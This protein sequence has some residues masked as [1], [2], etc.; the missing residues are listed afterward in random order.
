MP[1]ADAG[2]QPASEA[3]SPVRHRSALW[4]F[5]ASIVAMLA[6]SLSPPLLRMYSTEIWQALGL[7]EVQWSV[8]LAVRGLFLILF[9]MA[10]G[11]I[12]DLY[13][14]RRVL[15]LSLIGYLVASLIAATTSQQV[16]FL[17]LEN[18]LPL[19]DAFVKT[20]AVTILFLAFHDEHQRV[21]AFAAYSAFYVAAFALS[22]WLAEAIGQATE[23]RAA[24]FVISAVL[25]VAGLLLVA[26]VVPESRAS[27]RVRPRNVVALSA[28]VVG[29]CTILFA[30]LLAGNVGWTSPLVL[31]SLVAGGLTLVVLTWLQERPLRREWRVVLRFERRLTLAIVAGVVLNLSLFAVTTQ[32]FN[33]LRH[34]Q[35]YDLLGAVLRL[36]PIVAGALLLGSVAAR[37]TV[38]VGMR[39]AVAIGLLLVAAAAA[40]GALLQPDM[41]YWVLALLLVLL[42]FG[43]IVGN[44]PYLLLLSSS[45]P[46]D[47]VATAQAIGRTSSQMGSALAYALMLALIVGFGRQA[48]VGRGEAAGF[49]PAAIQQELAVL[50]EAAGDTSVVLGPEF[51]LQML[52]L[53]SPRVAYAYTVGLSRAMLVLSGVCVFGALLVY[54][55]LRAERGEQSQGSERS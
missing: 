33:F 14:R 10:A 51:G 24:A 2:V 15:L 23:V 28:W 25:T 1:E 19:F 30:I 39:N 12:G 6:T 7:T 26:R 38:R 9:V 43:F 22:P 13:G 40:G 55:G 41:A 4:I 27:A 3:A 32:I 48:F 36:G 45:V 20:L 50:S 47:L 34:V 5:V 53:I 35:H 52:E 42:G 17:V 54:V 49:S 37:L 46:R 16:A 18:V 31:G 8:L 11:V 21:R 44:A 29:V